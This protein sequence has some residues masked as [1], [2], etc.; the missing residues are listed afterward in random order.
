MGGKSSYI[1]KLNHAW[2]ANHTYRDIRCYEQQ[3]AF[4]LFLTTELESGRNRPVLS[5]VSPSKCYGFCA[6]PDKA[7]GGILLNSVDTYT[8]VLPRNDKL[9]V[10]LL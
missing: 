9:L 4:V 7:F 10:I 3:R 2:Q 5:F 1:A 8:L 6:F